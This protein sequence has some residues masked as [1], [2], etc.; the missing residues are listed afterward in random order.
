MGRVGINLLSV[1]LRDSNKRASVLAGGGVDKEAV[2][3]MV[4]TILSSSRRPLKLQVTRAHGM[5][6]SS[7]KER[8][9][10]EGGGNVLVLRIFNN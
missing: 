1:I 4:Y 10:M 5:L 3:I 8:E 2:K 7:L 6:N 9:E